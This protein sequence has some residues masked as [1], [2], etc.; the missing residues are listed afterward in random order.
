MGGMHKLSQPALAVVVVVV[1]VVLAV[2]VALAVAVV[3]LYVVILSAAKNSAFC[4]RFC[5]CFCF[6]SSPHPHNKKRTSIAFTTPVKVYWDGRGFPRV[7]Q[8]QQDEQEQTR[9][10]AHLPFIQREEKKRIVAETPGPIH[11]SSRRVRSTHRP[12]SSRLEDS[13]NKHSPPPVHL[14]AEQDHQP[15][16]KRAVTPITPPS[17]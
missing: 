13:I 6:Y 16:Q 12:R 1:G 11:A 3:C 7:Y 9:Q 5:F 14:T 8:E 17:I 2:V 4:F 10:T 15:H